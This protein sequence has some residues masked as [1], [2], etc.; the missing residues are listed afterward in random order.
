MN[1]KSIVMIACAAALFPLSQ[2]AAADPVTLGTVL[3][4]LADRDSLARH[5]AGSY[6]QHQASS[7]D[8]R[9]A[10]GQSQLGAPWGFM[11]VDFGNYIRQVTIDGRVERVVMEDTGPGVL[12]RWWST[13]ISGTL[14]NSGR[15]RIYLDGSTTPVIDATLNQLLAGS[16]HGFG[17]S[18]N[19]S[20]PNIGGNLYGPIPYNTGI[21]V[22][23]DGPLSHGGIDSSFPPTS[24]S[25]ALWYNMNYRKLAPGTAVTSFTNTA[26]T[27][28]AQAVTDANSAMSTPAVT[29]HVNQQHVVSGQVLSDG[30]SLSHPLTGPRAIRRLM[31][32]V[33]GTDQ[34]AAL[35][36]TFLELTFDGQ[37]TARVPVGHFFGNGGSRSAA[38]PYNT[39][40]D[41]MRKIEANG[42]MTCYWVMPFQSAAEVRVINESGQNVTIALQ[43][44]S[45]DWAWDADSMHLHV[46]YR[47]EDGIRTRSASGSY[48]ANGD[49]D[50][51]MVT[52][53]GRGVYVGDTLTA[54]NPN[55][56]WWGE[57][58]E[59]IYIDYLD[60]NSSGSLGKPTHLGTGT[61]DYY[62]YSYG[63]GSLFSN[64]FVNQPLADGNSS[65]GR[66]VNSR[67]RGLDAIP[68][69]ESFKFDL[70]IWKWTAGTVDF[71]ATTLWY[72]APG[73]VA[74][75]EAADLAVNF[76]SGTAGQTAQQVGVSDTA[77]DGHWLYFAADQANPTSGG[78][79]TQNLT[80]GGVGNAGN[81][82]F[83]GGQDGGNLAA[84]SAGFIYTNGSTNVGINGAPGYH[85]LAVSPAG[86]GV[87]HAVARWVAGP[88]SAGIINVN[89][90]IRNFI[91][92]G[93]SIDFAIYV[94]GVQKFAASGSGAT[95]AETYFEFD[96]TIGAGQFVDFVVG[97]GGSGNTSG[98]ES[99]LRAI[100]LSAE[101]PPAAGQPILSGAGVDSISG[102]GGTA[103][104]TLSNSGADVTLF[105]DTRDNGVGVWPNS[106][107]LGSQ[108]VGQVNGLITGLAADTR[109]FYRFRATNTTAVPNLDGWSEAGRSF[110][111]AFGPMQAPTNL[112]A[113]GSSYDRI[114][115][116]W[117]ESF[118]SETGF[119][120]ERAR[121]HSG[122]WTGV[123][124][125][126][127]NATS[128]QDAGLDAGTTY[129]YRVKARNEAGDSTPSVVSQATTQSLPPSN[130]D[131]VADYDF[132]DGTPAGGTLFGDATISGG[133][134][135][136][137]GS[138]DYLS[139]ASTPLTAI[140]NYVVE[141][142]FKANA[143]G[144][145]N[146]M[147]YN[148]N[149]NNRGGQGILQEQGTLDGIL[150]GV[151]IQG[152][153]AAASL[154]ANIALA[155]VREN[156]VSTVY[157]NG[158]AQTTGNSAPRLRR[159]RLPGSPSARVSVIV[160]LRRDSST[161][162][163]TGCAYRRSA[164]HS[165]RP[166]Y[167]VPT[168]APSRRA[169]TTQ[170]GSAVPGSV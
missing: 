40:K 2:R 60:G 43:V 115:L 116:M 148:G 29:G 47:E 126:P 149:S 72:G 33:S 28:Y 101:S 117:N 69:N 123:G 144:T 20:T 31:V 85:E 73:A 71:D 169:P 27:T 170:L 165:V 81:S 54:R 124:V 35:Q 62:G 145:F 140:N 79:S 70:E 133:V 110:G 96:T 104:A 168:T 23:W 14:N 139:F 108:P 102:T 120:V 125:A 56:G 64:P 58:D 78:A 5:P 113:T 100:I 138:G 59:K 80:W 118:N 11:N 112:V 57:G 121:N 132:S 86:S 34:V 141:A 167:L 30:Q 46:N 98:D 106:N 88:T 10:L 92:T 8:R 53:R 160:A 119:V 91:N 26:T 82:G 134:L 166:T 67:V 61:E 77:G 105:W 154:G 163:S 45:G 63:S 159:S 41:Y 147:V 107:P 18:L 52:I 68:F 15:Y 97:N 17:S 87:S 136:L 143:F 83:G 109:C 44:D 130:L 162:R 156:G 24:T 32:N 3:S 13:S 152:T 65:T 151:S 1:K 129:H 93:D 153:S 89:G 19:F 131:V 22:T 74:M 94:N 38:D 12:N 75:V 127:A 7:H 25:N 21:M 114:D 4:E 55:G 164:V 157:V 95:L 142:I 158:V 9:N 51:R 146:F 76:R 137:D 150:P 122:P 111:T 84:I 128:Y 155:L 161:E 135:N 36:Q 50:W 42:D 103:S 39:F 16:N 6:T 66:T 49:A 37:K 99:L 90:S 48:S